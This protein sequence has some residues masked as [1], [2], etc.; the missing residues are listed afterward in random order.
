[1]KP[2]ARSRAA[3]SARRNNWQG[4]LS[5]E[6][7]WRGSGPARAHDREAPEV[8]LTPRELQVLALMC[9]GLSNK[10]I[11][12]HLKIAPS[13]V[14]VHVSRI[15]RELNVST[16]LQAIVVTNCW[17]LLQ[18]MNHSGHDAGRGGRPGH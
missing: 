7:A 18:R 4:T 9:E 2:S 13:T 11:G 5:G 6:E 12:R 8:H 1:M 16:R 3:K 17:Q 10:V 15:L 14:K